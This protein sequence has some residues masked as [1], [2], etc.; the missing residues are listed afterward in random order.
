MRF[1][2]DHEKRKAPRYAYPKVVRYSAAGHEQEASCRGVVTNISRTGISLYIY[3]I[4]PEGEL[5]TFQGD[6]PVE[7][8]HAM[9]IWSREVSKDLFQA[10]LEFTH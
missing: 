9:V 3:T 6:L 1:G 8:R 10:G 7:P 4:L 5:I 2:S